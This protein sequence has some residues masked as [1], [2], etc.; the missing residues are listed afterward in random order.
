MTTT[1]KKPGRP[2]KTKPLGPA[3][4]R[5]PNGINEALQRV[6]KTKGDLSRELRVERAY[7]SR[8]SNGYYQPSVLMALAVARALKTTVEKLWGDLDFEEHRLKNA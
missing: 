2:K 1:K 6:G 7:V 4:D 3:A 5:Y 8:L